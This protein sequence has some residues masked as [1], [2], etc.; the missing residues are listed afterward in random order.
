MMHAVWRAEPPLG[1][2]RQYKMSKTLTPANY[3]ETREN[4][5]RSTFLLRAWM[6]WRARQN[7]FAANDAARQRLFDD[8]AKRLELDVKRF[9]PQGDGLLG[10]TKATNLFTGWVPDVAALVRSAA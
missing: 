5:E 10:N 4:P 7:G 3:G 9:Q 1:M 6:V 2:G 8:E